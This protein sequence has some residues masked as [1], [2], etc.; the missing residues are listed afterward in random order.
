MWMSNWFAFDDG[1]SI[2]KISAEGGVILRD[3]ENSSGARITL[4]RG[5]GYVSVSCNIYGWMD[6]TRFFGT[7]SDAQ[8]EYVAMKAA[9]ETALD[10]IHTSGVKEIKIWEAISEFV[11][12]FP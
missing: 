11:R 5:S 12:R 3:D 2:G 4:K 8:R 10:V 1:R 9:L 7:V 6:H